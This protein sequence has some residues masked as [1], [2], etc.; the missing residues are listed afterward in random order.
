MLECCLHGVNRY[1]KVTKAKNE[2]GF[3]LTRLGA[4]SSSCGSLL[5]EKITTKE[6]FFNICYFLC[7]ILLEPWSLSN[8]KNAS[9]KLF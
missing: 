4:C 3:S 1:A 6:F 9:S 7:F 8:D 5:K 2:V